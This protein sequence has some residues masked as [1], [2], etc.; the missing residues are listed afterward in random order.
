VGVDPFGW[1]WT[2]LDEFHKL[3]KHKKNKMSIGAET[4]S[5][6]GEGGD[7]CSEYQVP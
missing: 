4:K 7:Q 5:I 1:V 3:A 6:V 2:L